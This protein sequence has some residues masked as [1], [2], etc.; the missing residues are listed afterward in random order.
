MKRNFCISIFIFFM[1]TTVR[2]QLVFSCDKRVAIGTDSVSFAPLLMVGDHSYFGASGN[3]SI[4]TAATPKINNSTNKIG[5]YGYFGANSNY[6]QD[7]NF[8]VLGIVDQNI[9]H[10]RNYGLCGM[11]D[12]SNQN[13]HGGA[14]IYG[15]DCDYCFTYPNNISGA[16]AGFFVGNVKVSDTL[17]VHNMFTLSDYR[18]SDNVVSLSRSKRSGMTTLENLLNMNVVEYNLKGRQ[19]EDI[20]GDMDPE[21]AEELRQELEFLKKED[22][23]MTS[24]RHFGVDARELQKVYPD[25]VLESKDGYLSVNYLEMVPLVIRSIQ[26]LKEEL[27]DLKD[28][29]EDE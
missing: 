10:G 21:K 14:G 22:Q 11:I 8:G 16:Y 7:S 28:T 19:F 20:S 18:L 12:T 29:E 13:F 3:A 25:L 9:I 23:K 2:A 4:G 6:S 17:T 15:T 26:E 24:R 1:V 27:D 5:V